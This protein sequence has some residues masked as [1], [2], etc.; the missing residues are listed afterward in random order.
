MALY[1]FFFSKNDTSAP[2]YANEQAKLIR[3]TLVI[4]RRLA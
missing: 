4:F 2:Q 1:I 3:F